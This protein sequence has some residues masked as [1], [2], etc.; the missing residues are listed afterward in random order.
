MKNRWLALGLSAAMAVGLLSGCS[1]GTAT[2]PAPA[3]PA[4]PTPPPAP[5]PPAPPTPAAPP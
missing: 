5:Q 4:P 2:T 3:T 1:N